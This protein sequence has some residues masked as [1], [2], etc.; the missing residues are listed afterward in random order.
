MKTFFLGK[1]ASMRNI[2][3]SSKSA[4]DLSRLKTSKSGKSNSDVKK[5]DLSEKPKPLKDVNLIL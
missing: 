2:Q 1:T 3:N 4:T 5:E